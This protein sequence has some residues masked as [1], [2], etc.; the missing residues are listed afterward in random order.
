L[1]CGDQLLKDEDGEEKPDAAAV[2]QE[3]L[4]IA[5][6]LL[7]DAIKLGKDQRF[8]R[9]VVAVDERGEEVAVIQLA[10]LLPKQC[11]P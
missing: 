2:H 9:A 1:R 3:A 4:L 6:E 11:R 10:G 5:R 7:A 8:P